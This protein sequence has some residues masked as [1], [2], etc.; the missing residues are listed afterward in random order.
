MVFAVGGGLVIWKRPV[1]DP[2]VAALMSA[3]LRPAAIEFGKPCRQCGNEA[4]YKNGGACIVC[5]RARKRADRDFVSK[6]LPLYR[7]PG[8]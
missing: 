2:R 5:N 7:A 6:Q 3:R 4:R 1:E 8:I